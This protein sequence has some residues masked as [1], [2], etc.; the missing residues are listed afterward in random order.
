[1]QVIDSDGPT[2]IQQQGDKLIMQPIA[3]L[4]QGEEA[5]YR[6]AAKGTRQGDHVLRVQLF[7]DEFS[8]PVTKEEITKVYAD[9]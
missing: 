4:G 3:E 8:A 7:S 1:M 6:I 2:G 9:K 5:I